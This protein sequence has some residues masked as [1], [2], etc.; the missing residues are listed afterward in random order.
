MTARPRNSGSEPT[1]SKPAT[2]RPHIVIDIGLRVEGKLL[3]LKVGN[4]CPPAD[5]AAGDLQ[6]GNGHAQQ[7]IAHRLRY[8]FGS[9]ADMVLRHDDGYY[10]CELILPIHGDP[11]S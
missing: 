11:P 5:S 6:S 4:P 3:H 10:A 8:R 9:S 1:I 7:S 2:M